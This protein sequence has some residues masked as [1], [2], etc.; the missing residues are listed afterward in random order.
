MHGRTALLGAILIASLPLSAVAVDGSAEVFEEFHRICLAD[1]PNFLRMSEDAHRREWESLGEVGFDELAPIAKPSM[2]RVWL[3][4]KPDGH[5]PAGTIIGVTEASLDGRAVDTCTLALPDTDPVE[6][7]KA[8]FDKTDAEKISE[9]RGPEQ[10]ARLFVVIV[11]GRQQWIRLALPASASSG[12]PLIVVSSIVP[13]ATAES[14][15]GAE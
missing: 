7:Q 1:G 5:L 4:I 13:A 10:I 6:F 11:R 9:D 2:V 15:G 8:L 3:T 14:K 12:K